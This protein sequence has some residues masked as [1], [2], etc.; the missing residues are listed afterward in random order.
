MD[1]LQAQ[2]FSFEPTTEA[3]KIIHGETVHAFNQ[4]VQQRRQR[5]DS[6]QGGLPGVLWCVL[7][8]GA[9]GCILLCL[10]FQVDNARF[11]TLL[12]L[13]LA[14]FLSMV[15]FVIIALDRPFRGETGIT[16]DPYQLIRDHHM[17]Q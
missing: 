11:Q 4:L 16:A 15:L 6:V 9:S 7:L 2:L 13:G 1:R 8:P 5:L 12:L 14:G 10:F 17:T 3:Q